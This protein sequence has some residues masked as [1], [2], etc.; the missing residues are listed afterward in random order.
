LIFV[1]FELALQI[2]PMG[3]RVKLRH[4]RRRHR[5][6]IVADYQERNS[7]PFE[8]RAPDRKQQAVR[9]PEDKRRQWHLLGA[10]KVI[11]LREVVETETLRSTDCDAGE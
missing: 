6:R 4:D 8:S 11:L 7:L 9:R 3:I 10:L 2:S 1:F 5:K